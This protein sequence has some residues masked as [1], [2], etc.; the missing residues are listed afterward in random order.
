MTS[1]EDDLSNRDD[2][3]KVVPRCAQC[4]V[5]FLDQPLAMLTQSCPTCG[6]PLSKSIIMKP[7]VA[8]VTLRGR[9]SMKAVDEKGKWWL[10]HRGGA[11]FFRAD[12]TWHEIEQRVDRR[13]RRYVKR[14]WD[15]SGRLIKDEDKPLEDQ[16]AHEWYKRERRAKQSP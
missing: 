3:E 14:V 12:G 16:S 10:K 1:D 8:N 15:A 13:L 7:F 5:N 2:V 11:S 6:G 9:F 4:N